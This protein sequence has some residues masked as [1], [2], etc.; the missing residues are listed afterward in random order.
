MKPLRKNIDDLPAELS[1]REYIK[2]VTHRA[3]KFKAPDVSKMPGVEY[4]HNGAVK[5]RRFF[6]SE[7]KRQKF[8]RENEIDKLIN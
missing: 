1:M 7:E 3:G 4:K 8:I 5:T 2:E 6:K